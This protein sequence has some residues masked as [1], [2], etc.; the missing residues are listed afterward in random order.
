M[1]RMKP[2]VLIVDDSLTVRM[3]LK[4]S[5]ESAG[6]ATTTCATVAAARRALEQQNAFDVCILDVLL[7]DGDGLTLLQEIK[8]ASDAPGLPVLLLSAEDEVRDRVRGLRTGA[9]DYVGKPYDAAQLVARARE[10]V[11][12]HRAGP[13]V[14]PLLVL[15]DDSPTFAAELK[16]TLKDAGYDVSVAT[17]GEEGLRL[18]AN[19]RPDAVVVDQELPGIS[20]ADV[21]RRMRADAVLGRTPCLLLTASE[22][23][24]DELAALEAGA[25]AFIQKHTG[26]AVILVK[27]AA[28]RRAAR[29]T[30]AATPLPNLLT[31]KRI[32]A[33]DDS[34]T[35][36][37]ELCEQLRAERYDVVAALSGEE[38]LELL[39]TQPVDGILL[40]LLMPG[41]SGTE[42]CRRIKAE[43]AWRDI[44]LIIL[45]ALEESTAMI[46]GINAGADDYIAKSDDFEIL[47]ARL[48]AQLRR[49]Q[50][51]DENRGIREQL[52]RRE[53][54]AVEIQAL[55]E[56]SETRAA[57]IASLEQKN[58]ELGR[59]KEAADAANRELEAFSYSVSHDLRAP[60]RAISGL[61]ELL[62]RSL[63]SQ[64]GQK[65]SDYAAR[66]RATVQRMNTLI[67]DLLRLA[68]LTR[69]EM[70]HVPV[71][72]SAIG[73][74]IAAKLQ[75][76]TGH[77]E[78][79]WTIGDDIRATGDPGL[80]QVMM[81]NLLSNAWKYTGKTVHARI[82]FGAE[83]HPG[84]APVYHVADN[85]AG[86]DMQYAER[87]FAPFQRLHS[88]TEF[89]GTG[90]G[91]A[92]VQRIVGMHNGRIWAE[93]SP[94]RGATFYFTLA[95]DGGHEREERPDHD[96]SLIAR[97]AMGSR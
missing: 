87:L 66:I 88:E 38:A 39:G 67:E 19:L 85:G 77:R 34:A 36:L 12:R 42:A 13:R 94:D 59:A 4:E 74:E 26:T 40:D 9:D 45:T 18:A 76:E 7:P 68:S 44:P 92:T 21:I 90:V 20:G 11:H 80:L 79:E 31:P 29:E 43:P 23:R 84:A 14:R 54:E 27:L 32:L 24:T 96:Q 15:I 75:A 97:H 95:P 5:F 82:E 8:T 60:L 78:V 63:G 57:L 30:T 83:K 89:P 93:A 16:A 6:F 64:A 28:V 37:G 2:R 58:A 1:S 72:L 41:L 35:F 69:T 70:R 81:E 73:R 86:F 53:M 17:T 62:L 91:L 65:T 49:K 71:D 22:K 55:R 10:L 50:F 33:V 61:T 46:E 47:K 56:L 52:H 3:D 25:D 48:R 51:E